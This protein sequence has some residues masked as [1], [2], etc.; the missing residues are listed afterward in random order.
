MWKNICADTLPL[1]EWCHVFSSLSWR[2]EC[3][4][5]VSQKNADYTWKTRTSDWGPRLFSFPKSLSVNFNST[6]FLV[7]GCLKFEGWWRCP[8]LVSLPVVVV[9]IKGCCNFESS[10]S[11]VLKKRARLFFFLKLMQFI[12][13]QIFKGTVIPSYSNIEL[14]PQYS[15]I[16]NIWCWNEVEKFNTN[17]KPLTKFNSLKGHW[18]S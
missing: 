2:N 9:W 10:W 6:S 13:A 18:S 16:L 12:G 15:E 5:K 11:K 14:R 3:Q 1:I 17:N 8:E 4:V 7:G